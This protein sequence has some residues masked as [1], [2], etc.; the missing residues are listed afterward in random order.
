MILIAVSSRATWNILTTSCR[1]RLSSY[2]H[3]LFIEDPW[4]P[5]SAEHSGASLHHPALCVL[6]PALPE[7]PSSMTCVPGGRG[8]G[9][10]K[11]LPPPWPC[12]SLRSTQLCL[13]GNL[14][15]SLPGPFS[16][17]MSSSLS[18][19]SF[20]NVLVKSFRS[21]EPQIRPR[22]FSQPI[23]LWKWSLH[24]F[25]VFTSWL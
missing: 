24:I 21:S 7:P 15:P 25:L 14:P 5:H 13:W 23:T 8:R 4:P 1:T 6:E 16:H 3:W 19:S 20:H 2:C 10:E 22:A 17:L 9:L 18:S 11:P 12:R